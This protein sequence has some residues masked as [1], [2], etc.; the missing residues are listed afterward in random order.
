MGVFR[1]HL[2]V[3]TSNVLTVLLRQR[4]LGQRLKPEGRV[5]EEGREERKKR[6]GGGRK[7]GREKG[8]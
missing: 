1:T 5:R 6:E 3:D 2:R 8:T 4:R 7:E